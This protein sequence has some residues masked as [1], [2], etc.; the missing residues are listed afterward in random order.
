MTNTYYDV[1]L[2][3]PPVWTWEVPLY[4]FVGGAAGG[5]ALIGTVADWSGT[6]G[7]LSRDARWIAA[8][9]GPI[10]AA[11]LTADLGRPER[12]INMLRVLK[13]QSAMS[14]GSWT[15]ATFSAASAGA[16]LPSLARFAGTTSGLFGVG[17]LTYTGVLIGATAIPVWH[18]NVRLLPVHFA[19]SGIRSEE[20]TSELQSRR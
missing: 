12:F 20:H 6:D 10:S 5:A 9:G 7:K 14:V 4:F 16:L 11:L 2:L 13:P 8:T 18:E 19:A 1:P 3:K 15:L 17:M